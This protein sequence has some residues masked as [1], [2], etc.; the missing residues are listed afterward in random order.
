[1]SAEVPTCKWDLPVLVVQISNF[2]TNSRSAADEDLFELQQVSPLSA[3]NTSSDL[4]AVS[5]T[6]EMIYRVFDECF[7]DQKYYQTSLGTAEQRLLDLN[8]ETEVRW[9]SWYVREAPNPSSISTCSTTV[10]D[11]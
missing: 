7:V 3:E 1:M 9:N 6:A 8:P 2:D 4:S 10:R 5:A 11:L